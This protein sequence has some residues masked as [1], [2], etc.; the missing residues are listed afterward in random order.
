MNGHDDEIKRQADE[1][2]ERFARPLESEYV[3]QFVAISPDGRTVIAPTAH[4][5][6][7]K[8]V[9]AFG[10]GSF[11]FRVGSKIVWHWR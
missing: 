8:A 7:D 9:E 3:G 4:E 2:Y 10:P 11:L 6:A 1:L 5:A